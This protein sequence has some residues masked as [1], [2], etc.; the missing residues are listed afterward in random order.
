MG[1]VGDRPL[2]SVA[3]DSPPIVAA[4]RYGI[5][6]PSAHNT[7]PWRIE[8]ASDT[9]ARV[10]LDPSRLLPAT[11]PPGRQM[12]IG[13]G[14]L[15]EMT[16]IAATSLGY[17]AEIDVLPEGEMTTAEFGTR[18]TAVVRL[19]PETGIAV[20]PLFAQILQRRSSRLAHEGPPLT[21][22][23][24]GAILQ[25]GHSARVDAAWVPAER[26]R[27]VLDIVARATAV[28]VKDVPVYDESRQWF[29]FSD[30]EIVEHGDG[31]TFPMITGASGA[32]LLL[33]RVA[34]RVLGWHAAANRRAYLQVFD[35]AVGTTPGLLTL[36]T[37][38]NAMADWIATGRSYVRA[39][40]TASALGLRFHPVSQA[41]QEFPQMDQLRDKLNALL[42]VAPPAKVQMLV[43]VGRTKPPALS[44][45]R[46]LSTMLQEHGRT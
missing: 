44:P 4:L 41:L 29:R 35:R 38:T 5:T 25:A 31:L 39:Q 37:P 32:M 42:G 33:T 45:R 2:S 21:T 34:I 8:F 13:H 46:D 28:E 3:P 36:I 27:A 10:F 18:P 12:H 9:A 23:E 24:Q 20:D 15:V 43:R 30:R 16:A 6:A 40:L 26:L 11:D 1:D 17:R 19:L 14:T 22:D 7:Q